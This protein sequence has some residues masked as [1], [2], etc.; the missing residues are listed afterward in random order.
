MH[1]LEAMEYSLRQDAENERVYTTAF[2]QQ[3][4]KFMNN[5]A[6]NFS[7]SPVS[8]KRGEKYKPQYSRDP[9]Y[10]S[11]ES[12]SLKSMQDGAFQGSK[13]IESQ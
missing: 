4:S 3:Q 9:G 7:Y 6:I 8:S 5:G 11:A 10:G 13:S 2:I 12:D 1:G